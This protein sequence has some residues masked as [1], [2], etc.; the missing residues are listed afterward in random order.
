MVFSSWVTIALLELVRT[1][2]WVSGLLIHQDVI[3]I[4][5]LFGNLLI[6]VV[7]PQNILSHSQRMAC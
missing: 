5:Y 6:R 1:V 7:I 4:I 2:V 3:V